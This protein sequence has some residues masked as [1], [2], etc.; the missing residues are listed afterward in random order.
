M[1]PASLLTCVLDP[2]S[3]L[4]PPRTCLAVGAGWS[5]QP[6]NQSEH[7]K[8]HLTPAE[9]GGCGREGSQLLAPAQKGFNARVSSCF[10]AG[11]S[12]QLVWLSLRLCPFPADPTRALIALMASLV[13]VQ[14]RNLTWVWAG[15]G[16]VQ[17]PWGGCRA[18]GEDRLPHTPEAWDTWPLGPTVSTSVLQ[19]PHVL[20]HQPSCNPS[21]APHVILHVH[22]C[23]PGRCCFLHTVLS[24]AAF[25]E[26][27]LL[28]KI[29]E[30]PTWS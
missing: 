20:G 23:L 12:Q 2:R 13:V 30:G 14:I 25:Q 6:I 8:C 1:S 15:V 10:R 26:T 27:I 22:S 17:G 24:T 3:P 7:T 5:S 28:L 4:P 29:K 16:R 9:G 19:G 18:P 21:Q 11:A